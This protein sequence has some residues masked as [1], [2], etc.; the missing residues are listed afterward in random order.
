MCGA[1]CGG[2]SGERTRYSHLALRGNKTCE[3]KLDIF[4]MHLYLT[5]DLKPYI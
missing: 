4:L 2:L 3:N 1:I 5:S